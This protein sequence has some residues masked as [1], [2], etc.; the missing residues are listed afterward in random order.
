MLA[1]EKGYSGVAKKKQS[2]TNDNEAT[3]KTRG[4]T[5]K[6]NLDIPMWAV[7][8]LDKESE[9]VGVARQA[10]IKMWIIEKIDLL[11][12]KTKK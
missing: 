1:V 4:R 3:V 10:L 7:K 11:A 12:A 9:R 8:E 2:E 6:I 5:K